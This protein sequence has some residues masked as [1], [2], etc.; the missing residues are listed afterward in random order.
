MAE[1]RPG[2]LRY[3]KR[4]RKA[5]G[6]LVAYVRSADG[7]FLPRSST[8]LLCPV[9]SRRVLVVEDSKTKQKMTIRSVQ[10]PP[11]TT[12]PADPKHLLSFVTGERAEVAIP[13][14]SK[15][16]HEQ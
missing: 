13:S 11:V 5:G 12:Y 4:I 16:R 2:E 6:R 7:S 1:V 9:A 3:S 14:A 8:I 10:A 15:L